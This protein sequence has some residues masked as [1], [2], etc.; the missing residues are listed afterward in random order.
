M[1]CTDVQLM[2]SGDPFNDMHRCTVDGQWRPV[3]LAVCHICTV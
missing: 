1:I 2:D 3:A